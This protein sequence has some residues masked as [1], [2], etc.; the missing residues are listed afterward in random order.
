M[1]AVFPRYN[2]TE[3]Y[4]LRIESVARQH[5]IFSPEVG[6]QQYQLSN[7]GMKQ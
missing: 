5:F 7:N 2:C 6:G 3:F 4:S 1:T